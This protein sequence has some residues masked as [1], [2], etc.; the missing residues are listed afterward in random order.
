MSSLRLDICKIFDIQVTPETSLLQA[1][2]VFSKGIHR[3]AVVD[4]NGSIQGVLTQSNVANFLY[5][6]LNLVKDAQ[7]S[8]RKLSII[9]ALCKIRRSMNWGW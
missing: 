6:K 5:G 2:D 9:C 1:M 3:L 7:K 8:V 4:A